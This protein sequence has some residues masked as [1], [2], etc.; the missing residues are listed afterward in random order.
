[1]KTFH[2]GRHGSSPGSIAG[3]SGGGGVRQKRSLGVQ[4]EVSRR[5]RAG[6]IC[7]EESGTVTHSR[8]F[9]EVDLA[10]LIQAG[11]DQPLVSANLKI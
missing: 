6:G 1:M 4:V 9:K 5:D 10:G 7:G 2:R 3:V 11:V 8:N